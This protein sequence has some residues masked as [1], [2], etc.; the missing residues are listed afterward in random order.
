M[1]AKN[2]FY[3]NFTV[4]WIGATFNEYHGLRFAKKL[5]YK[6]WAA[7]VEGV[8]PRGYNQSRELETGAIIAWHTDR[9]EMGVHIRLSG[10]ALR[11]YSTLS[12][13]W[14]MMLKWVKEH[15]GRTSRVD[16]ALDLYNS[17][18][19]MV[20]FTK[21]TLKPYVG[22]GRTPKLLPVGTQEDGWTVYVGSRQSDKYLRIYDK[23]KEQ[24]GEDVDYIRVELETKGEIAHAVGYEFP[25]FTKGECVAMAQTLI[26]GVANFDLENW[27]IAL[28]SIDVA[29]ST[30]QGKD[31]D[32]LGWL[33]KICA[34]SLAKTIAKYPAKDVMGEFFNALESE[35]NSRGLSVS[36][37]S[38][39]TNDN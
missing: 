10:A 5:G 34:P 23:G 15:K 9:K 38:N 6:G 1:G 32:T 11:Y 30:P 31:R 24:G 29:L 36:G 26:R 2:I 39:L 13:D 27:N 12:V 22:K 17:R 8:P 20:D 16:L 4:D 18:L 7:D 25:A 37:I 21:K 35:L 3:Q 33:V 28:D 14:H 19:E